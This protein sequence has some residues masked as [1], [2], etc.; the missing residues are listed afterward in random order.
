MENNNLNPGLNPGVKEEETPDIVEACENT[1]AA[2][3]DNAGDA[4]KA[5]EAVE[6]TET[7]ETEEMQPAPVGDSLTVIPA[8]PTRKKTGLIVGVAA[9]LIAACVV[10][11]VA[12]V[13]QSPENVVKK[14]MAKTYAAAMKQSEQMTADIPVLAKQLEIAKGG[15]ITDTT[16]RLNSLVMPDISPMLN[17]VLGGTTVSGT[18]KA[19]PANSTYNNSYSISVLGQKL[20]TLDLFTSPSVLSMG[21]PEF[22]ADSYYLDINNIAEAGADSYLFTQM[23]PMGKENLQT[24]ADMYKGYITS[25]GSMNPEALKAMEKRMGE[26]C[27]EN[28]TDVTYSKDGDIFTVTLPAQTV[29]GVLSATVQYIYLESP[30]SGQM[31]A[32]LPG[33]AKTEFINSINTMG[34]DLA[35]E[36]PQS[37]TVIRLDINKGKIITAEL[38]TEGVSIKGDFFSMLMKMNFSGG[39]VEQVDLKLAVDDGEQPI[40][41]DMSAKSS[42]SNK[43]MDVAVTMNMADGS[44]NPVLAMDVGYKLD[45]GIATNNVDFAMGYTITTPIPDD[46]IEMKLVLAGKGDY[47][48]QDNIAILDMGDINYGI[49]STFGGES[50]PI[51]INLDMKVA[52]SAFDGQLAQPEGIDALTLGE[53]DMIVIATEAQTAMQK[54]IALFMG[55]LV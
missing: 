4:V 12:V 54:L 55:K 11:G 44:G 14:A 42:Y 48:L 28:L 21:V 8:A 32:M 50:I 24:F 1:E 26:I 35:N 2:P 6:T 37:P 15:S 9:A 10:V 27:M 13:G 45:G 43:V 49:T 41:M 23:M 46:R 31:L 18:T 33:E 53:D 51:N 19:D 30:L 34:T 38:L 25:I 3:S 52:T 7:A 36:L 47:Y 16:L 20:A 29:A 22:F 40:T 5:S 39:N 17:A